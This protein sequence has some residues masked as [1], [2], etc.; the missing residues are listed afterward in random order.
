MILLKIQIIIRGDIIILN[1]VRI[2]IKIINKIIKILILIIGNKPI[3]I[4]LIDKIMI[5]KLNLKI[6]IDLNNCREMRIKIKIYLEI[7]N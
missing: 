6:I 4:I 3:I 1:K 5:S 2:I 7:K